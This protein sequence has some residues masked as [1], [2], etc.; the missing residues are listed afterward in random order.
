M[1]VLESLEIA[2]NNTGNVTLL[3]ELN[4]SIPRSPLLRLFA[5]YRADNDPI[6]DP[7]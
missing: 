2:K 4:T 7:I 3:N 1:T 6:R 5:P